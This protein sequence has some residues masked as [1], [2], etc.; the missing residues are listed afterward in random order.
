VDLR[1]LRTLVAISDSGSF[2]AAGCEVGLTQSAVSQQIKALEEQYAVALFNRAARPPTLTAQGR[3]LVEHARRI[4]AACDEAAGVLRGERLSGLLHLGV[5]RGSLMGAL[6]RGLAVLRAQT[7]ALKVRIATGDL[8][9]LVADV[10]SGKLDAAMIP[11]ASPFDATLRW[12]PCVTE[13]FAAIA[14]ASAPG[15]TDRQLLRSAP[16]IQFS[17]QVRTGLLIEAELQRRGIGVTTEMEIDSFSGAV[18]LVKQGLGCSVVPEHMIADLPPGAV[19]SAPFGSPP[20]SRVIGL[21]EHV[22]NPK[23]AL[24]AELRAQLERVATPTARVRA[25]E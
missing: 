15:A 20:L 17:R 18:S 23:A 16:Y 5:L 13:T 25:A 10:Q 19:R 1:Q 4:L 21:I 7:P 22:A 6:P 9:D 2:G 24:I 3:T 12:L 8:V 11:D 14:P